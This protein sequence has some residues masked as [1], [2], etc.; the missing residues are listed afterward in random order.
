MRVR[1]LAAALLALATPAFAQQPVPGTG[2]GEDCCDDP[3]R[4]CCDPAA[5]VPPPSEGPVI[6]LPPVLMPAPPTFV[7]PPAPPPHKKSDDKFVFKLSLGA[8]YQRMLGE[9]VG[10]G[11]LELGLGAEDKVW[12]MEALIGVQAG[13]MAG[14]LSY[15]W[16]RFGPGVEFQV[17]ERWRI[18]FGLSIGAL[19][20]QRANG[21][22]DDMTS[23]TMGLHFDPSVDL[24]RGAHRNA[25]Y[26]AARL[27]GDAIL[28]T[29]DLSNWAVNV[30]LSLGY[31]F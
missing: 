3:A 10:A 11:L 9:S 15:V 21:P 19:S 18:G 25:L 8:V 23:P 5:Q 16:F 26:L 24:F 2:P 31:R 1:W 7:P 22:G 27:G 28:D 30:S 14:G 6:Y 13:A 17:G 29:T 4:A 12:G 20:I